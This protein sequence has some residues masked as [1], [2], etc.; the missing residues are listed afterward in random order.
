MEGQ[1]KEGRKNAQRDRRKTRIKRYH[2][3]QG[4][5]EGQGG[6]EWPNVAER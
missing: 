3:N 1:L 6:S 2:G 5:K 4:R